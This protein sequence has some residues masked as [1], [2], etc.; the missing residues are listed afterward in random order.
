[1]LDSGH[2]VD[3]KQDTGVRNGGQER[4]SAVTSAESR[5]DAR[6]SLSNPTL[7]QTEDRYSS[8]GSHLLSTSCSHC[9]MQ[10]AP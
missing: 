5:D 1:M 6:H 4:G 10:R 9:L 3:H 8:F 2:G 7:I